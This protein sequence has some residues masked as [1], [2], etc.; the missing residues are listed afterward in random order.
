MVLRPQDVC[1]PWSLSRVIV[2]GVVTLVVILWEP[3]LVAGSQTVKFKLGTTSSVVQ[4]L[5]CH[6]I[7][8]D[9]PEFGG[10]VK[11]SLEIPTYIF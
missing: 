1:T 5:D 9:F 4:M 6:N 3:V 10:V 2:G 8:S 7:N 11:L